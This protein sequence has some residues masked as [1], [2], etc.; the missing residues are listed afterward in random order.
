MEGGEENGKR[1]K[2]RGSMFS[3]SFNSD[4]TP[5]RTTECGH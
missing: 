2:D 1:L 5:I 4:V 3:S